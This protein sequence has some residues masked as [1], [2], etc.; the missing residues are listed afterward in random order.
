MT[1]NKR[2][3]VMADKR[4]VFLEGIVLAM[5]V[6]GCLPSFALGQQTSLD[7][8]QQWK[9]QKGDDPQWSDSA[10]D[11]KD[12]ET[13][14]VGKP[15]DRNY[16]GYGWYRLK[17]T[18]PKS[19]QKDASLQKYQHLTLLLGS[20][21][22]ADQAWL[23]GKLVGQTG[24]LTGEGGTANWNRLRVYRVP[25]SLIRW[26]KENVIAVR[27]Y[28]AR[29]RGGLYRG[30]YRLAISNWTDLVQLR[31]GLGRGDGIFPTGKPMEFTATLENHSPL[32]ISGRLKWTIQTDEKTAL[33]HES[34]TVTLI[35]GKPQRV[36]CKFLPSQPGFYLASCSFVGEDGEVSQ[37]MQ[38]GYAPEKLV[39]P[40][41]REP[42]FLDFWKQSR[43]A[44]KRVEPR[45]EVIAQPQAGNPQIDVYEVRMRSLG[46][47]RVAGWYEVPKKSGRY[48]AVL[49]LPGYGQN[50]R[51]IGRCQDMVVFSFNVRGHGN[52]QQDVNGKPQNYWI[53]GLDDKQDYYYRGAY[54]DCLRAVDFLVSRKEV[55]SKR[56]AVIGGSQGGGFSFATAAL[57]SRIALCAPDIPFMA[58]FVRYFQTSDWPE[59]DQW[60]IAD[61]KR[62]WPRTLRTLSY[63][64]TMNL[65]PLIRCP[66]FMGVGL[67]DPVCPPAT[68]FT[69]YNRVPAEKTYR[70][71]PFAGHRVGP[72]HP[73]LVFAWIRKHFGL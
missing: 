27:V 50:M 52:S 14:R 26:G 48:P 46:N 51:P 45:F 41:T 61:E 37:R 24:S 44:L 36:R 9:F 62:T 2:R 65:A 6:I 71:Y 59:M 10:F 1:I 43:E 70:V 22:D 42:D 11:D 30:P 15:W 28:D 38:L 68:N 31:L 7:L 20:I 13:I 49:R 16:D 29:A 66:V 72:Q 54:L 4:R 69:L 57:D 25:A 3:P 32:A 63:F 34:I 56:I 33:H 73:D 12:W 18:I 67:Q 8:P 21:D 35:S 55:D 17:L 19:W 64:D 60:I 39:S 23:N 5:L 40:L 47:V 58:D 53:R